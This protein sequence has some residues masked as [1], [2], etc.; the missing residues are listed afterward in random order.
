MMSIVTGEVALQMPKVRAVRSIK[1]DILKLFE[2]YIRTAEDLESLT[3]GILPGILNAALC[4]Y[5]NSIDG[6]R[7]AEVLYMAAIVIE[8]CGVSNFCEFLLK[9]PITLLANHNF[10]IAA[11][12]VFQS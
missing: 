4:D 6:A 11:F 5:L 9:L 3:E 1:K 10:V 12:N 7:D 8:R 2:K